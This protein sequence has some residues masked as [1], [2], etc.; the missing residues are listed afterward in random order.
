MSC[1]PCAI[2]DLEYQM[3]LMFR[4]DIHLD[5]GLVSGLDG[6]IELHVSTATLN[7]IPSEN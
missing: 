3:E 2:A 7:I 6:A 1:L 4:N 5:F